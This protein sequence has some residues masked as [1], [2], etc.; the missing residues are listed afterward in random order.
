MRNAA[1]S[2]L[3]SSTRGQRKLL[4]GLF[5][6]VITHLSAWFG[7]KQC[8]VS[9]HA[10]TKHVLDLLCHFGKASGFVVACSLMFLGSMNEMKITRYVRVV[11][12]HAREMISACCKL[13]GVYFSIYTNTPEIFLS[14]RF[15]RFG[16]ELKRLFMEDRFPPGCKSNRSLV[17]RNSNGVVLQTD[18]SL[19]IQFMY[20]GYV[21]SNNELNGRVQWDKTDSFL[22]ITDE[23]ALN[24]Q[25]ETLHFIVILKCYFSY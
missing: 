25:K 3:Y 8:S 20:P 18:K 15:V 22:L 17:S 14:E 5:L 4:N 16:W 1:P 12:K 11:E 7:R 23:K 6:K 13:T 21:E 10:V 19:N 2:A 24:L 9:V